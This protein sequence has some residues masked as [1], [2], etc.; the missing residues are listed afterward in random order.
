MGFLLT[1][2][3]VA[4]GVTI[5]LNIAAVATILAAAIAA[6]PSSRLI[7]A[8][9]RKV[10]AEAGQAADLRVTAFA[11]VMQKD[12]ESL[13]E[14]VATLEGKLEATVRRCDLM[15][16]LLIEHGLPLPD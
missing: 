3:T 11:T 1:V 8:N 16:R 7:A 9:R 12:N 10:L 13:R 14:R 5:D 4:T 6:Y 2:L 15:E